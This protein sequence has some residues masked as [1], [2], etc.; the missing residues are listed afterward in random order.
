MQVYFKKNLI[1]V[2]LLAFFLALGFSFLVDKLALPDP[3]R[4]RISGAVF[5]DPDPGVEM[6]AGPCRSGSGT[7]TLRVARCL[8]LSKQVFIRKYGFRTD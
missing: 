2:H 4:I 6:N 1:K 8:F 5:P 3:V 7:S